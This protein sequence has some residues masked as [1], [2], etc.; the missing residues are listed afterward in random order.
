[1]LLQRAGKVFRFLGGL[2]FL[3][4][5]FVLGGSQLWRIIGAQPTGAREVSVG[6]QTKDPSDRYSLRPGNRTAVH[7]FSVPTYNHARKR[8]SKMWGDVALQSAPHFAVIGL[9]LFI[10][11]IMLIRL[12]PRPREDVSE[13]STSNEP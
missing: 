5:L 8:T 2:L 12:A 7:R 13:T 4:T 6:I 1:M 3:S 11:G 9:M 10:L